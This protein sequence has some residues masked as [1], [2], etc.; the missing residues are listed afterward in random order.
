MG[1]DLSLVIALYHNVGFG[2]S[3]LRA[4]LFSAVRADSWSANVADLRNILRTTS[5]ASA[6]THLCSSRIHGRRVWLARFFYG[7]YKRKCFVVDPHQLGGFIGRSL[8]ARR[9][10]G[11]RLAC[12]AHDRKF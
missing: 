5:S 9:D 12:E 8:R 11:D 6:A 3:L 4:A 2:E 10:S 7:G 1:L